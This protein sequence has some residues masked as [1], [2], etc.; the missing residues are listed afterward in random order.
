MNKPCFVGLVVTVVTAC[1]GGARH[2]EGGQHLTQPLFQAFREEATGEAS[3]AVDQYVRVLDNAVTSPD[4]PSSVP[5]TM[6]A[7][8]A[9]VHQN[10]LAFSD[11]TQ[12]SALADRTDATKVDTL[13]AARFD[14]AEGPFSR[15]L[16]ARARLAL[17]EEA[18]DVERAESMRAASGCVREAALIGPIAWTLSANDTAA[19]FG[20]PAKPMMGERQGP[21][22]WATKQKP[23]TVQ[24]VGCHLPLYAQSNATGV[25]DVVVDVDV[26]KAG[27]IGVGM[28]TSSAALLRAGGVTAIERPRSLGTNRTVHYARIEANAKGPLRLVARVQMARPFETIA[29]GAWDENGKPLVAHVPAAGATA[30]VAIVR[31]ASVVARAPKT[32]DERL[33]SALFALA[34]NDPRAAENVLHPL[35]S[36]DDL[37]PEL[38]LAYARAVRRV[39]DLPAVQASERARAAYERVL[40]TW[41]TSWEAAIEHAALS[42]ERASHEEA[43]LAKLQDLAKHADAGASQPVAAFEAITAGREHLYDRAASAA[44]RAKKGAFAA[45]R[46][47]RATERTAFNRTGREHVAFECDDKAKNDR[48]TFGCYYARRSA[49]DRDGAERELARLRSLA[50]GKLAFTSISVH[51]ALEV[52]DTARA[53]RLLDGM[54]PG[55]RDVGSLFAVSAKPSLAELLL[56]APFSRDA[57][58]ALFGIARA[59]GDD[60]LAEFEGVAERVTR[61]SEG[62][63]LRKGVAT[64]VLEHRERYDV[65]AEG[66]VHYV[67]FDVRRVMGTTDVESNAEAMA[68][69]LFGHDATRVLRRRILKK[70]GRILLPDPTPRASQSHADLSQLEAGDAVEAIYEGWGLAGALGNVG[71]DTPDLLPERTFVHHAQIEFRTPQRVGASWWSHPMLGKAEESVENGIQKRV[72]RLTNHDVRRI[73]HGVPKMDQNVAVSFSTSSWSDVAEG[74]RETLAGLDTSSPEVSAWAHS[75]DRCAQHVDTPGAAH[76]VNCG[77]SRALVEKVVQAAGTSVKE[78]SGFLLSDFDVGRDGNT[79]MTARTALATH[80]GSR[81]WLIV[82]ALRELG[83]H[84]DVVIAENEPFSDSATFPPHAGRFLHP[85]AVAHVPSEKD[86]NVMQDVWIDA[87]VPGP[88]LPAGRISP[89]LRGRSALRLDG[90]IAAL[91]DL[92]GGNERDEIDMRL[93][94]DNDGNAKGVLTVLLRGRQAQE[95]AQALLRIVGDERQ[96]A[97]RGIALAWAP[98]GTVEKVELSSTE[99]SWQVAI[100]AEINAPGY[101]L[102]EGDGNATWFLPGIEPIHYVYPRPYVT[103]LAATY[104]NQASR[105]SALAISHATQ[106]HL[107]RRVELPEQAAFTRL[108]GPFETKS[109]RV[110]AS[111]KLS[112]SGTS[113]DEDFTLDV[114]TGTVARDAYNAFVDEAHRTDNAF[115]AS[116]KVKPTSH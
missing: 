42:G 89:E 29:F 93:K 9:L 41:P 47:M 43:N 57:P 61:E 114:T 69:T 52:A 34:A 23:L 59:S 30:A 76:G 116:T 102:R 21:K 68:P 20:V 94:L 36:G 1:G 70:D 13:L 31:T 95:V 75:V 6:A 104:A 112:V 81:T 103:T 62:N 50:G 40:K 60:P 108:P 35:A 19:D 91:P 111:H 32:Q 14:R 56:R 98:F 96:R 87:D 39:P 72:W 33:A 44:E 115:R 11:V 48:S 85:L 66:L 64:A 18:G 45:S 106:Y 78:A 46:L 113:L 55:D 101:A 99:E 67:F 24:A 38:L 2:P 51:N 4:D 58:G 92:G 22:P 28:E 25:R 65:S 80:E 73:E 63:A 8:D 74:L 5:V 77:P 105:E 86:P 53:S 90:R 27:W 110:S 12:T 10:V 49:G 83:V 54:N 107:H 17:A 100:R 7:L 82:R 16:I 26:P 37:S 71:V 97:L 109:Q 84:T 79:S 15:H 3:R 88:P